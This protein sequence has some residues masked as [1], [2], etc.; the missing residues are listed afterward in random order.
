MSEWSAI[1]TGTASGLFAYRQ[2]QAIGLLQLPDLGG[3]DLNAE[4]RRSALRNAVNFHKPLTALSMFLGVVAL[5]DYLRDLGAR[6]AGHAFLLQH[7]PSLSQLRAV[8]KARPPAHAFKQLETEPIAS[9]EPE[10]VN[11]LLEAAI[12]IA[13]IPQ[14]EYPRLRDLALVRHTVAHHAAVVRQVDLPRFQ[15]YIVRANQVINPPED[16]VRETL[17]YVYSIG[18]T[19]DEQIRRRVFSV[20]LPTLARDWALS[21]PSELLSL[22]EF[23]GYFGFIE[24][25]TGPV[26]YSEPGTPAHELMQA[27]SSRIKERLICRCI[28]E[29]QSSI[30]VRSEG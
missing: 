22:F 3:G 15:Y 2:M 7:F 29:L 8:P 13:P 21:P 26:G 24:S 23:F 20:V 1:D 9:F 10:R 14:A 25:T 27:E 16:F 6:M 28:A 19:V 17:M 11:T 12:G 30:G 5:E 4:Q 18:R